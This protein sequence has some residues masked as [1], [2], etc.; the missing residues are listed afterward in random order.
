MSGSSMY[1]SRCSDPPLFT[2][3]ADAFVRLAH[4]EHRFELACIVEPFA[5][6][7]YPE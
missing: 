7:R 2:A 5:V 3:L 1:L 4:H 6:E